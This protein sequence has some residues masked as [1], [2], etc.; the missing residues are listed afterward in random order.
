MYSLGV[1]LGG[2][3]IAVGLVS[4]DFKLV[5]KDSVPTQN[6]REYPAILEDLANLCIKVLKDNKI[7]VKDV[8]A[9]GIGSPGSCDN[10]RGLIV[11]ANNLR[12]ENT[13][14]RETVQKFIDLPVYIDNDANCAALGENFA[15][16]A[17]GK[18]ISMT[19]TLGTGVGSGLV[20]NNKIFAGAYNGGA[21]FGHHVIKKGGE[22]CTCGRAGC[23]ESYA[24]A[25]GLI[26]ETK[27]A[28][29]ANPE[30]TLAKI[31]DGDVSRVNAKTAFD[32]KDAG[33]AVAIQLIDE[34][35]QDV[36][37]GLANIINML[38]PEII[39]IGGGVCAQ[40]DKILLPIIQKTEQ[41]VYG[42]K[43]KTKIKIAELGN[44][45]GIIGAAMLGL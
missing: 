1:D 10:E 7:D 26:R 20:I 22:M 38:E 6:H 27:R 29:E 28:I 40:G 25:T 35:L 21:E 2:T 4:E 5:A 8:R 41:M 23:W 9:I 42:G 13:P 3:N 14:V 43:M 39:V 15:G 12:F 45:A 24:S 19:I 44:D 34:Y 30:S 32:A 16:A 11:Y 31:V 37:V 36:A 33:D 18:Q 17:K